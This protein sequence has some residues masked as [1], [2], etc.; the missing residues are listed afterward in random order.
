MEN[1]EGLRREQISRLKRYLLKYSQPKFQMFL[2]L[3]LTASIGAGTSFFLLRAGLTGMWLRYPAAAI[4]AYLAFLAILRLWVQHKF[5]DLG[6][7]PEADIA[8]PEPENRPKGSIWRFRF[9]D[10]LD[11]GWGI[12]DFPVVLFFIAILAIIIVV[13]GI[14]IAAPV[15]IAEVLVDGL[16]VT[17]LW[18]RFMLYGEKS[19]L[20]GA[21]R[22]TIFPAAIVVVCLGIIGFMLQTMVPAAHS[23]GDLFH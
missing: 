23:I 8:R 21:V 2:I 13:V 3:I 14:I 5:S 11:L 1:S 20:S 6:F 16:L 7:P 10:F 17:G 15:L 12:D 18:H 4:V 19:S 22:A 9:I